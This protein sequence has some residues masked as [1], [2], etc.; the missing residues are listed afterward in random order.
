MKK[1]I[2]NIKY[3][4]TEWD[5]FTIQQSVCIVCERDS[6]YDNRCTRCNWTFYCSITCRRYHWSKTHK[7]NCGVMSKIN[8]NDMLTTVRISEAEGCTMMPWNTQRINDPNVGYIVC[9]L[10]TDNVP[11][12]K[13][14]NSANLTHYSPMFIIWNNRRFII[15]RMLPVDIHA[16]STTFAEFGMVLHKGK[17]LCLQVEDTLVMFPLYGSNVSTL[18]K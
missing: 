9:E 15:H 11:V 3:E 13:A 16:L 18:E 10:N 14:I 1:G 12:Q 8:K 7:Y 4:N 6:H 17:T 5:A 2:K